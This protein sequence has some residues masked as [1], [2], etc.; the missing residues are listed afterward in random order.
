LFVKPL[1]EGDGKGIDDKSIV[2]D[3]IS[4]QKKVESIYELYKQP[5]LVEKFI[6]GREFTVSILDT[7]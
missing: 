1:C 4:Y 2:Y 6:E 7:F 5:S 3:F